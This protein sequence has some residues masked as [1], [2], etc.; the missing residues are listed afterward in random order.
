MTSSRNAPASACVNRRSAARISSSSPRARR[1]ASGSGG[2]AR[3]V[4]ATVTWG[5]RLSR[6][7]VTAS[8]TAAASDDVVVVEGEHGRPGQRVEVVEQADQHVFGTDAAV[9]VQQG[10]R[11]GAGVGRGRVDGGREVLQEPSRVVVRGVEGQ[12]DDPDRRNARAQP[13]DQQGRLTEPG[14]RR[15]QHEPWRLGRCLPAAGRSDERGRRAVDEDAGSAAWRPGPAS[16]QPSTAANLR[17]HAV[18]PRRRLVAGAG[19]GR[20]G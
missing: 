19:R 12:P 16:R 15:D 11:R 8:W 13:L 18:G 7:N 17:D 3:L 20:E 1:R 14:R 5:G 2:S 4:I 6:R 10:Q 9:G